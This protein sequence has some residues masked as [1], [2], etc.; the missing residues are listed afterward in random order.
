[1]IWVLAAA[2][3]AYLNDHAVRESGRLQGYL[4]QEHTVVVIFFVIVIKTV[5]SN[6]FI[7]YG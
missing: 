4:E 7:I 1:M 3:L 2:Q 6:D 5:F